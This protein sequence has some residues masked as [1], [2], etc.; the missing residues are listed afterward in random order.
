[1]RRSRLRCLFAVVLTAVGVLVQVPQAGDDPRDWVPW[2]SGNQTPA[3]NNCRVHPGGHSTG[4]AP[5]ANPDVPL[6]VDPTYQ[7]V[8]GLT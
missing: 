3:N 8:T 5:G 7:S 2:C 1:M 4:D 6:G